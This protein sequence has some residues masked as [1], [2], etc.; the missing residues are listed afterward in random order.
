MKKYF[1]L[2]PIVFLTGCTTGS[3]TRIDYKH[4]VY[5]APS[6][7]T[8]IVEKETEKPVFI[9]RQ[10]P[11]YVYVPSHTCEEPTITDLS[12]E[13]GKKMTRKARAAWYAN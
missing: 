11:V 6:S 2:I 13:I 4:Y 5:T 9:P 1:F 8:I 7:Q 10:R 3:K 12:K